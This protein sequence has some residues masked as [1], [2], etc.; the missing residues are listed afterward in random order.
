MLGFG[1]R[2]GDG[3]LGAAAAGIVCDGLGARLSACA[4]MGIDDARVMVWKP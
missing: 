3:I 1:D 4:V 2:D